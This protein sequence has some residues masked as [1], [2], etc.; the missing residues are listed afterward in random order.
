MQIIPVVCQFQG[1]RVKLASATPHPPPLIVLDGILNVTGHS[2]IPVRRLAPHEG[3]MLKRE[4]LS[5]A[6]VANRRKVAVL[7][8]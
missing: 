3:I 4:K 5:R 1:N 2:A 8:S 7:Q 6:G